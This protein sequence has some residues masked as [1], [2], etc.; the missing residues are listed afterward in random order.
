MTFR[1]WLPFVYVAVFVAG[2]ATHYVP[3]DP[4]SGQ[5]ATCRAVFRDHQAD[6]TPEQLSECL[7]RTARGETL[8]QLRE[9]AAGFFPPPPPP[10]PPPVHIAQLTT[11][12]QIFRADGEP[13][14]YRGVSSFKL[15]DRFAR[16][17]DISDVLHAYQGFNV[18]RVWPYVTWPGA[19]WEPQSADV[20][21]AFLARVARDGWYVEIT[22]LTD[23]DPNRLVWAK[24]FVLQLV[25]E[26]RPPNLLLEAGNEPRTH[27]AIDTAAL[28]SVL[29]ASG[30][31]YTSGDYEDSARMY[32]SYGVFHS[33]R[34]G[35]W[36][37][38]SHDAVEYYNGGGPGAPSD[39]AHRM[40]MV[41]DEPP[42]LQDVGGDRVADWLAYFASCSLMGAGATAHSE[43]GKYGL[44]PTP[45]EAVLAA[46]ALQGL[47][48]FPPD[49][50]LGPYRRIDESGNSLRTYAIGSFMVRVRPQTKD[51]PEAGWRSLDDRGIL[52]TR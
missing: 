2:C 47:N 5:K 21:R 43:T 36:P 1:R 50:P 17:E 41:A 29:E 52:F 46:A 3:G 51:A 13:W 28:R 14:R 10:P 30:V 32:G 6:I 45:D 4:L 33:A 37:R 19:G 22:L 20:T 38:R 49:A 40:P 18:L 12:R 25:A 15:L 24:D 26:P 39:P 11:D 27:K 48:A 7:A 31:P 42:K 8:E 34:D 9:W 35:E 23:D 16:G 44:P